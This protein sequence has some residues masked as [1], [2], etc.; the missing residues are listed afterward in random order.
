M[1]S[2]L[3]QQQPTSLSEHNLAQIFDVMPSGL[4]L[5]DNKG[6]VA[7]AN[8]IAKNLLGK[9]IE[10]QRWL[11]AVPRLFSPKADDG[12]ELSLVDGRR[13]KLSLSPLQDTQGQLIVLT[14]MTHTRQLQANVAKLQRMSA[15]GNMV[16]SLAHQIRTPLSAAMLYGSNLSNK[17]LSENARDSFRTKMMARLEDLEIQV[18]DMLLFAKSGEQMVVNYVPIGQ[19]IEQLKAATDACVRQH[20]V[21][22]RLSVV[23]PN[24]ELL[25][26]A[27]ALV[28]AL[29]N[30]VE[31]AAQLS[32][33]DK[34][35][36]VSVTTS[37]SE[38]VIEV[39]DQAGGID[40]A[41]QHKVFEPFYTT[42]QNGTGLGLAVVK[43]VVSA[44]HGSIELTGTELGSRFVVTLPLPEVQHQDLA[45]GGH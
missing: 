30:L 25:V 20:N 16:A 15:L 7:R 26:N 11:D 39:E 42:K 2:V 32:G 24:T 10:Q 28:S 17:T 12:H 34:P 36:S 8:P 13:V 35:I 3:L 9:D 41:Q 43:S 19:L 37:E 29:S 1:P 18:N 38:V 31:N 4:V 23:N 40:K 45:V 27:S 14:D 22:L 6:Y 44:H 5:L 21:E 33:S